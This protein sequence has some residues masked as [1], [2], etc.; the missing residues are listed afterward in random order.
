MP[1][2]RVQAGP[3]RT[4]LTYPASR[5]ASTAACHRAR[6]R[7]YSASASGDHTTRPP[8]NRRIRAFHHAAS[9]R[10]GAD[11]AGEAGMDQG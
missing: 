6:I 2:P 5:S 8:A 9:R 7:A 3:R 1:L 11:V 10:A 4:R